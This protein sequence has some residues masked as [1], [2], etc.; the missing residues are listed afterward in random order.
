MGVVLYSL[1]FIGTEL[2]SFR[3]AAVSRK[4]VA[5]VELARGRIEAMQVRL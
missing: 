2:L 5:E 3:D 1:Q 4:N